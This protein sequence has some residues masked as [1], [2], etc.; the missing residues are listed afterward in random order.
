MN[1]GWISVHRG[2]Q[3]CWVWRDKPFAKGQA[4]IDILLSCN[5]ADKKIAFGGKPEVVKRGEWLTSILQL[6]ERWGWSR[7]K[8]SNF[9]NILEND[10]MIE[11]KR[12][13]RRTIIKVLNYDVYQ[14]LEE[15]EGTTEEHQRNIRGT[16]EEHQRNTNNND[17]NNNNNENNVNKNN[18]YRSEDIHEIIDYL[19]Q[20]CGTHYRYGDKTVSLIRTRMKEGFTVDDFKTVIDK[21]FKA[22]GKGDMAKYL[23]PETLFGTKFESYLNEKGNTNGCIDDDERSRRTKEE[24]RRL[25]EFYGV[26]S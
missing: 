10:L 21:K 17:N 26:M 18:I 6:S 8:V 9:L 24:S 2:V 23:R 4:W 15:T 25:A 22:W 12:N 19:N 16:S 1:K 5:H 13:N 11:Q 14:I 7:K 20:V 3:D